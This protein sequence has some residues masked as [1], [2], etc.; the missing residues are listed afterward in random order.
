MPLG[1]GQLLV[2]GHLV[3]FGCLRWVLVVVGW[4]CLAL[5]RVEMVRD[6]R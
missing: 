5:C 2:D 3:E 4:V 1:E 6:S